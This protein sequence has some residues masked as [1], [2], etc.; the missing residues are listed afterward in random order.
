[1]RF[2]LACSVLATAG[3]LFVPD[4]SLPVRTR[5]TPNRLFSSAPLSAAYRDTDFLSHQG[6]FSLAAAHVPSESPSD[7]VEA[8]QRKLAAARAELDALTADF[9]GLVGRV[10]SEDTTL[11][12]SYTNSNSHST[13]A[14]EPVALVG[15][16]LKPP[17]SAAKLIDLSAP[18]RSSV[19]VAGTPA[20]SVRICGVGGSGGNTIDRLAAH[21]AP[22]GQDAM[23]TLA[24]NTDRQVLETSRAHETLLIAAPA[25][26]GGR[27]RMVGQGA[28]GDPSVGAAAA[29]EHAHE[30]G[31]AL[32]GADMVFITGGMGGGTG[33]GVAP[34]VA[35]LARARGA[36]TVGV[37]TRPFGFEG[38]RRRENA[39]QAILKLAEETDAL[40]VISNDRLLSQLP[41]G[42]SVEAAFAAA[43]DVLRQAICAVAEIVLDTGLVNVDFND[44]RAVM[45]GSG[46][47]L[48]GI[49]MSTSSAADA[50]RAAIECP[51]LETAA[52]NAK[53]IVFNVCGGKN[54]SLR[55]VHS[56]ADAI[57][58]I[59][60][61][62]AN[63]IFG[64]TLDESLGDTIRVTV[65]ATSIGEAK[66]DPPP[67]PIAS[68]RT[69]PSPP[70]PLGRLQPPTPTIAFASTPACV[71]PSAVS[72]A[73]AAAGLATSDVETA[74]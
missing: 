21:V 58:S 73:A 54:L 71:S 27:R 69:P 53:G 38:S 56:A 25:D 31:A 40:V 42:T 17:D 57:S 47:A 6:G 55:E 48:V 63:I 72:A 26:V 10:G 9:D 39:N 36:L 41:G 52:A 28:G 15:A 24:I 16:V 18:V 5:S 64:A 35:R 49:G 23:R 12:I 13:L 11:A 67:P 20:I 22:Y 32:D 74:H 30:V 62:D 59:V 8:F 2:F 68:A 29:L 34:E 19:R 4:G 1:M 33:S 66:R 70:A 7:K 60:H 45:L 43:D 50:A 14:P 46:P 44:L 65:I 51:L 61:P 37:V 3:G